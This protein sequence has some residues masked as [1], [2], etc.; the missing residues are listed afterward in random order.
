MHF[1]AG[2]ALSE[3]RDVRRVNHAEL[4]V[5]AD[6]RAIAHRHNGLAVV[7]DLNRPNEHRLAE[8]LRLRRSEWR[9]AQSIPNAVAWRSHGPLGGEES[10]AVRMVEQFPLRAA[11]DTERWRVVIVSAFVPVRRA[12]RDAGGKFKRFRHCIRAQH[13][14]ARE[15]A[16]ELAARIHAGAA[17]PA[18][19]VEVAV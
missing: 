3:P 14:T 1:R 8:N 11:P 18:R 13:V 9:A 4:R 2:T 16:T 17:E 6:G 5:A 15:G 19:G 10:L 7:R 12:T